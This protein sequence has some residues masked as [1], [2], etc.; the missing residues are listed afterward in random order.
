MSDRIDPSGQA[1]EAPTAAE[2]ADFFEQIVFFIDNELAEADCTAVRK[3]LDTCN[4]CLEKYD[5]QRTMKA[6]VQ[7]SCAEVAP[8]EL[9][10]KV[11]F[12]LQQVRVEITTTEG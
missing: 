9:R 2:C 1:P 10:S 6:V 8:S 11:M 7:R 3:H 4:P 5:L 12:R